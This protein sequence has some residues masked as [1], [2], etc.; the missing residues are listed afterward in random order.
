MNEAKL[1]YTPPIDEQFNE[2][3]EKAIELW[4]EVDT[5]NDKYG[6]A[7]GKINRIKDIKNIE[8]NF[9]YIFSMFDYINQGKLVR[10]ISSGTKE[11]IKLRMIDGGNDENYLQMIGL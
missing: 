3:K 1:Y 5:D 11:A 2:L 6:Y 9:M 7:T 8:D 4:K 10:K